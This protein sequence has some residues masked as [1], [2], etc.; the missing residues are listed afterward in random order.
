MNA[1]DP[2]AASSPPLALHRAADALCASFEKAW[3][4][5]TSA[6]SDPWLHTIPTRTGEVYV[7]SETHAGVEVRTRCRV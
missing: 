2:I 3:R 4:R 1:V 6:R 5:G 7:H